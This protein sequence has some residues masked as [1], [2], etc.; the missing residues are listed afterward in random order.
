MLDNFKSYLIDNGYSLFTLN[1]NPSTV[2]DYI[3]RIE[4]ICFR[5]EITVDELSKEIDHYVNLYGP[6]GEESE[7]GKKSHGAFIAAL[8]KFKEFLND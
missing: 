5:E 8:K 4:K 7:F 6:N 1:G 3:K 2:F